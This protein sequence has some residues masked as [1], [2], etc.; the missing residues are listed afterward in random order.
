MLDILQDFPSF[1]KYDVLGFPLDIPSNLSPDI[2]HQ[3]IKIVKLSDGGYIAES[4]KYPNLYASGDDFEELREAFYDTLLTYF[5]VPR[6]FAKRRLDDFKITLDDGKVLMAKT[7]IKD[8]L[9]PA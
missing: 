7:E 4:K 3:E 6:Y 2:F 9:A 8:N 5:D 1:I